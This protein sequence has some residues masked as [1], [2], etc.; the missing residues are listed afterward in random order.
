MNAFH[1]AAALTAIL[2]AA[3]S[4]G[5]Q[6]VPQDKPVFSAVARAV[7][8]SVTVRDDKGRAVTGLTQEDFEILSDDVVKPIA[9]FRSEPSPITIALL[10]DRS[11]SMRMPA[12]AAAA[13]DAAHHLVSWLS[14]ENDRIGIFAFDVESTQTSPFGTVNADSL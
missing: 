2:M 13:T 5:S 9:N 6:S 12:S 4:P 8:I 7:P 1:A 10:V 14:P 3:G 11:G